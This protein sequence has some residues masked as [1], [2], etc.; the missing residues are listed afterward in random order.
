MKP[1]KLIEFLQQFPPDCD[2]K[3]NAVG[4]LMVLNKSGEYIGY[5]DFTEETLEISWP[6]DIQISTG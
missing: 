2:V 3:A 1:A 6:G 4:N 5:I